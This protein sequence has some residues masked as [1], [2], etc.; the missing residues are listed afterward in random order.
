M[1]NE[2]EIELNVI[3]LGD[4]GV[5]KT[6]IINIIKERDNNI[7]N[8]SKKGNFIIRRKY[9]KKNKV[10][11]LNLKDSENKQKYERSIPIQYIRDSH[12]VLLVFC[13]IET[14]NHL[15]DN[16]Y[17]FYIE[18]KNIDNPRFILIGNKSDTFGNDKDEIMKKGNIFAEE[19]DAHF[20]TCSA[21]SED[22]LDN[23]ERYITTEAKR[24]I[25]EDKNESTIKRFNSI[26]LDEYDNISTTRGC[27]CKKY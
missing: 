11:L 20:L 13:N 7:S 9:E 14:L 16:L 1:K 19:I 27:R 17:K 23:V 21:K 25:D 22:N 2:D 6:S 12:I 5:G 4:S 18:N 3:T 10:I 8:E 15:I 26:K 24:Y